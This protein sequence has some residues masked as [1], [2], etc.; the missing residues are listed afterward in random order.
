MLGQYPLRIT[1]LDPQPY[2]DTHAVRAFAPGELPELHPGQDGRWAVCTVRHDADD[3][4]QCVALPRLGGC[5]P[6]GRA[7]LGGTVHHHHDHAVMT[8][9][10]GPVVA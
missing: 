2:R 5:L 4:E 7:R 10:A 6:E 8:R 1:V 9:L 3:V